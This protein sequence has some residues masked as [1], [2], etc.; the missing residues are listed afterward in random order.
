MNIAPLN[1]DFISFASRK[2]EIREADAVERK[3]KLTF[4]AISATYID[5]FYYSAKPNSKNRFRTEYISDKIQTKIE[6]TR[7]IAKNP[8]FYIPDTSEI[9]KSTL[10]AINLNRLKQLKMGNCK[11]NAMAAVAVLAANGYYN[12]KRVELNYRMDLTD[13]ITGKKYTKFY[14]LDHS[15]AVTDMIKENSL[16]NGERNI[17]IDPWLGFAESKEGAI[18]RFK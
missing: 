6:E 4:P 18:G 11:E 15:F 2:K 9:E 10:Y 17:V 5:G 13:R 1:F 12:S 14:P 16:N 8:D 3:T 7:E